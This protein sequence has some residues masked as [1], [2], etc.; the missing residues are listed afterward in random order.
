[1]KIASNI[2]EAYDT[3]Q[4]NGNKVW[5]DAIK[6]EMENVSVAF[7]VLEDGKKPSTVHKQVFFT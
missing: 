5:R 1:M 2:T 6:L 4:E 7:D 3:D